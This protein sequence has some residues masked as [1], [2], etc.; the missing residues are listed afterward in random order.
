M[1]SVYD[2]ESSNTIKNHFSDEIL[3]LNYSCPDNVSPVEYIQDTLKKTVR[4]SVPSKDI[5][6]IIKNYEKNLSSY[7]QKYDLDN[8]KVHTIAIN[9]IKIHLNRTKNGGLKQNIS[10]QETLKE[11]SEALYLSENREKKKEKK[12]FFSRIGSFFGRK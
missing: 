8:L 4:L 7:C 9:K 1:E 12:G 2:Q 5:Q 6:S 10:P 3:F 11:I